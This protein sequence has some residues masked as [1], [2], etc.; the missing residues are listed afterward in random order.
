MLGC[1][2][3]GPAK[4][5]SAL[6]VMGL[7]PTHQATVPIAWEQTMQRLIAIALAAQIAV[8]PATA[9]TDLP[10]MTPQKQTKVCKAI[11]GADDVVI[12]TIIGSLLAI[13]YL[14]EAW[15]DHLERRKIEE[16]KN[17]LDKKCGA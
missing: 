3:D 16:L 7:E 14:S 4:P 10:P 12:V 1:K 17:Q 6:S 5:K 2:P 8:A 11:M 15:K 13:G 9:K